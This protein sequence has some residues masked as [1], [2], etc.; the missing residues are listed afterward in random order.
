[1]DIKYF[2]QFIGEKLYDTPESYVSQRLDEIERKIRLFFSTSEE[3]GVDNFEQRQKRE[4]E[5][6]GKMTLAELGITLDS[7]T[8]S[9]YSKIQDNIKCKFSDEDFLYDLTIILDLK[10]AVPKDGSK[11]FSPEDIKDCFIKFK[12][13]SIDD[14]KLLSELSKNIKIDKLDENFMIELKLELDQKSG[15][16]S[17]EFSLE[18]E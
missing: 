8:K 13:Y 18:T 3:E 15:G 6:Q 17:E 12:K 16:A 14:F 11:D 10:D 7:I 4:K 2:S 9:K 1:M 5:V